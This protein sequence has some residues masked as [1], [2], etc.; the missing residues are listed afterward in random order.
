MEKYRVLALM[1]A[2][3]TGASVVQQA[4]GALAP[5]LILQFGLNKAAL[6]AMFTA[7]YLGS[8]VFTAFSGALV[9]RFGERVMAGVSGAVMTAALV[10]SALIPNFTWLSACMFVFGAGYA[11]SMPAGGRAILTWFDR[12]RGFA[13]GIRQTGV[14]LG[15]LVGA[16]ML[17]F[18]ALHFGGYRAALLV[19]AALVVLATGIACIFYREADVERGAPARFADLLAGMGRLARDPRMIATTLTCMVLVN[20]QLALNGFL[21]VTAVQV[22]GVTPARAGTAFA[23]AFVAATVAR[24]FWGWYSDRFMPGSRI[25]LLAAMCALSAAASLS[26]AFLR[27]RD[28]ALL[29]P[30]AAFI[31]FSAAGWNGVMAA[32]LAEI[33]GADRAG[34]A[35]GLTLTAVFATSSIGPLV[36]GAIADHTSLDTAWMVNAAIGMLGILPVL[37]LRMR[38]RGTSHGARIGG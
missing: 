20:G 37:W 28:A 31:G 3:Q 21:T 17:P 15:G 2:A 18:A 27:P 10:A 1:T 19:A 38:E 36:F 4:V 7:L 32:V 23:G 30:A 5:F 22:I 33:G 24:L 14:P 13:M 9:D 6:G 25:A 35:I 29:V 16:V 34:S 26:F 8:T 11:A 12:D